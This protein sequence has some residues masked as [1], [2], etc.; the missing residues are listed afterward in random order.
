MKRKL[1]FQWGVPLRV[2]LYV[3]INFVRKLTKLIST[4][5]PNAGSIAF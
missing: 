4:S 3:A 1:N 2:G 5:I